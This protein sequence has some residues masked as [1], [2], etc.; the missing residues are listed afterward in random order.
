M[1]AP[2]PR[3]LTRLEAVVL[4]LLVDQP[5]HGYA[6]KARLAPGMPRERQVNDGVLYPLLTRLEER[7]LTRHESEAAPGSGP[8]RRVF[9]ATAA[10]R[11]AFLSWLR[12]DAEEEQPVDYELFLDHPLLKLLFAGHLSP[13][14]R[15]QKVESLLAASRARL[16]ALD[17]A[18]SLGDDSPGSLGGTVLALGRRREQALVET[19][20]SLLATG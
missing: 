9:H 19:L 12:S 15:R 10:G 1:A 5:A 16:E 7:G 14:E 11:D 18:A 3:G 4:G 8:P 2:R 20:E 13:V 6:L 17:D